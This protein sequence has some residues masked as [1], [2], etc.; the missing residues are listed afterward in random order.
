MMSYEEFLTNEAFPIVKDKTVLEIGALNDK[1]QIVLK[2]LVRV[3]WK[4]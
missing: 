1:I 4:Q 3:L 2:M